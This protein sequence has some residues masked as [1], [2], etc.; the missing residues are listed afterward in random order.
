MRV[1]VIMMPLKEVKC[2]SINDTVGEAMKLIDDYRLLS[3]T[4][5]YQY[6]SYYAWND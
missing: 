6:L 2:I 5:V 3:L 4:V 1:K